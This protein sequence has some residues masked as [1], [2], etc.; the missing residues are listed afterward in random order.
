MTGDTGE[1]CGINAALASLGCLLTYL[2]VVL[3]LLHEALHHGA[4]VGAHLAEGA[5]KLLAMV[6]Q[7]EYLD[8]SHGGGELHVKD[9]LAPHIFGKE[10]AEEQP[11]VTLGW[12]W[13]GAGQ[14]A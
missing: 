8:V 10:L 1:T 6:A 3:Q 5:V 13:W 14:T 9:L 7:H 4:A 2:S 11:L 12:K